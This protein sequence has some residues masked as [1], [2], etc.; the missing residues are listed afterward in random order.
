MDNLACAEVGTQ[1]G[2]DAA[3]GCF[4][5]EKPADACDF[6]AEHHTNPILAQPEWIDPRAKRRDRQSRHA[7]RSSVIWGVPPELSVIEAKLFLAHKKPD[8]LRGSVVTWEGAGSGR[9]VEVR[10]PTR[11]RRSAAFDELATVCKELKW[12]ATRARGYVHRSQLRNRPAAKGNGIP[13]PHDQGGGHR[14]PGPDQG[15]GPASAAPC[16]SVVAFVVAAAVP[17]PAGPQ[18]T[19]PARRPG[20]RTGSLNIAGGFNEKVHELEQQCLARTL[21]VVAVQETR[22]GSNANVS[23]RGYALF[24]TRG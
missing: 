12:R 5:A 20:L 16:A 17:F 23:V 3:T 10:Y 1:V 22:L 14:V 2:I 4:D 18:A 8:I 19:R 24:P 21:D 13:P 9:H 15:V 11:S 7:Q 6:L